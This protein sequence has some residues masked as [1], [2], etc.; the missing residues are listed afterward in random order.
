MHQFPDSPTDV[1]YSMTFVCD[2]LVE[3]YVDGKMIMMEEAAPKKRHQFNYKGPCKDIIAWVLNKSPRGVPYGGAGIGILINYKNKV[4]GSAAANTYQACAP[5]LCSDPSAVN[6]KPIHGIGIVNPD[7]NC[8]EKPEECDFNEWHP[9]TVHDTLFDYPLCE[10]VDMGRL[11]GIPVNPIDGV[12]P[13][14]VGFGIRFHL[15]FCS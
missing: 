11:G 1:E 4:Y 12:I 14:M 5:P 8:F 9:V 2:D 6:V 10:F 7:M 15:P 3:M 13:D